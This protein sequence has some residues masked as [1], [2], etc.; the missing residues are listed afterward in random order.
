VGLIYKPGKVTPDGA[1]ATMPDHY[2]QTSA[3][4]PAGQTAFDVVGR[5]PL[6]QTFTEISSSEKFTVVINHFKSKSSSANGVGDADAGDG[7]GESNGTRVR[8]A[9]D[10]VT[11]LATKPTGTTDPDYLILGD[12]NAYAKEDPLTILA[13][14]G[15][16]SVLPATSYSYVFDGFT[17]SL[18]HALATSS[19]ASQV[20][21]ADKYHINA[22]EPGILDYNTEFKSAGQVTGYYNADQY[23]ASD[24]DPVLIGLHLEP[25]L[26]VS[27]ISFNATSGKSS[28]TLQW[29]TTWEDQNEGFDILRSTDG[30]NFTEIA[31]VPGN[32]TTSNRSDYALVDQDVQ[33]GLLYYYRLRQHDFDGTTTLS[34]IVA[35]RADAGAA[36][37]VY[38]NPNTGRFSLSAPGAS[39]VSLYNA[40]GIKV[41]INIKAI[42]DEGLFN[43][44]IKGQI[45][46][47]VYMLRF[48]SRTSGSSGSIKILVQ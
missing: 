22:D 1:P 17:G 5:K 35:A 28:V 47:G 36:P 18:D 6:A 12:L 32:A 24:H 45:S 9:Q 46:P 27:L 4:Y 42:S 10:L 15:Y 34:R 20:T 30:I 7:Q 13:N 21:K 37:F 11:W 41:P 2:G 3:G 14:A 43:V 33:D 39:D 23:R 16:S 26:P 40:A 31:F 25:A 19:L 48:K 44:D 8:Q 38:P 29:T